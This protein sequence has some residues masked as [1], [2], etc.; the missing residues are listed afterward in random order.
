MHGILKPKRIH[1]RFNDRF[2]IRCMVAMLGI[3]VLSC[4]QVV[5]AIKSFDGGRLRDHIFTTNTTQFG[6]K[7]EWCQ[8]LGDMF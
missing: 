5:R 2:L 3:M 6:S 7:L 4:R 1:K 8:L